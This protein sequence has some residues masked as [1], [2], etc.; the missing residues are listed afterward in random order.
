MFLCLVNNLHWTCTHCD[1]FNKDTRVTLHVVAAVVDAR[2]PVPNR[3]VP[4]KI[5]LSESK[6]SMLPDM[7][8]TPQV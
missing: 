6:K 1:I 4:V 2:I 7:Q 3:S 5:T 8:C